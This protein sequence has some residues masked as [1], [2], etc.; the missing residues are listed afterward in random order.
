MREVV[1]IQC[2]G[3]REEAHPYCSRVCCQGAV[4]NAI[5]LKE[6]NPAMTVAVLFRDMRTY[7][8][9]ELHYQKARDLGV[10]FIR[11]DPEKKPEVTANGKITVRV[12][13]DVSGVPLEFNPDALVLSAGVRPR[14]DRDKLASTFKTALNS[15]GFYLE[16][17]MELR[18]LDFANDGMFLAGIAHAPKTAAETVAQAKGAAARVATVLSHASMQLSATVS[19]V[20]G[21]RCAA[22]LTCVRM[23]PYGV[24]EVGADMVA[25]IE[26]ASCQGCGVC[27]SVCPRKAISLAHYKDEQLIAKVEA[28]FGDEAYEE[29]KG[30]FHPDEG[31]H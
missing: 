22:C 5:A 19:E 28:L 10:L 17:H 27:A 1:M 21:N 12:S 6:L 2:V 23:C 16:A 4:K 30:V 14:E 15:D 3:S 8:F 18:P 25:H 9:G 29:K 20:D 13:D 11:F 31:G 26:P 24:P 7:G